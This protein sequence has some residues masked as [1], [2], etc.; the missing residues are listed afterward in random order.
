MTFKSLA[1][2]AVTVTL[3]AGGAAFAQTDSTTTN[4]TSGTQGSPPPGAQTE[5]LQNNNAMM[6][7]FYT[8]ESMTT[9]KSGE[10]FNTAWMKMSGEDK[11]RVKAACENSTSLKDEFCES[12]KNLESQAQ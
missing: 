3:V 1:L 10:E 12:I 8:D 4:A 9:M 6:A 11:D 2:A 7:P 5:E